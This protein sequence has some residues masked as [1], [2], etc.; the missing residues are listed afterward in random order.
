[1]SIHELLQ[2]K[3]WVAPMAGGTTTVALVS[4]ACESGGFGLLAA[5]Y[6]PADEVRAQID[7]L[8]ELGAH[9]IGVNVFAR[10]QAAPDAAALD[11]YAER[12][13]P[14]A[15]RLGVELGAPRH[16]DDEFD[17]KID[18]LVAE[19]PDLVTF[20]FGMPSAAEAERL[21]QA[22]VLV[23]LTV[24][25]AEEATAAMALS[26]D[27]LIAQASA[28]GGHRG[29]HRLDPKPGDESL[30]QLLRDTV[31]LGVPI[32]AAGGIMTAADV[33][34]ALNAGASAVSCGTAFL[35]ADEAGTSK[36]HRAALTSSDFSSTVVT[37]AFTGRWARALENEWARAETDAPAGYPEVHFLTKGIRGAAAAAHDLQWAHL[38]AGQGW[39]SA[40][41]GSAAEIMTGLRG[42]AR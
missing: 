36:A 34:D 13:A 9:P 2:R 14:V 6:K 35:L 21:Q 25:S 30:A 29:S 16:D 28:A 33:Q 26:P 17:A 12:L 20:T 18:L 37:R 40:R 38:W 5:G 22:G 10:Q 8:R 15:D 27:L 11:R 3:V 41:Q 24:T 7:E 4:A 19:R 42:V 23:G 39:K 31:S 32:V 1:M